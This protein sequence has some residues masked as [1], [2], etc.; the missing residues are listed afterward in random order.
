MDDY[1]S[2][3]DVPKA[4]EMYLIA[5]WRQWADAGS[6]SSG[7]PQYLIQKLNARKIGSIQSEGFYLFQ[8]PGTHDL[9]R[10]VVKFKEGFPEY[11]QKRSNEFFYSGDKK[12]G[13][14]IFLGDEPHLEAERLL[15]HPP[16]QL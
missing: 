8:I 11:L 16:V 10:P 15:L 1:I 2:L 12:K 4:K 14:V 9:V 5:G 7:L 6:I 3:H 13:L